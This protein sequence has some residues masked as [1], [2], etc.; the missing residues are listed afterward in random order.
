M[1]I[2]FVFS[3]IFT[4]FATRNEDVSNQLKLINK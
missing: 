1:I 4:I 3:S 2:S